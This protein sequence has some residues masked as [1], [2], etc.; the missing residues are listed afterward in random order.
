MAWGA[1]RSACRCARHVECSSVENAEHAICMFPISGRCRGS[2]PAK[3]QKRPVTG[4]AQQQ[5][6]RTRSLS[7]HTQHRRSYPLLDVLRSCARSAVRPCTRVGRG[8][9]YLLTNRSYLLTSHRPL[10][11]AAHLGQRR[12]L[13]DA[14][15]HHRSL[16]RPVPVSVLRTQLRYRIVALRIAH[17]YSPRIGYREYFYN[18]P[19]QTEATLPDHP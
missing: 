19:M 1:P 17:S 14:T 18:G 15:T 2:P 8:I 10:D 3:Q 12:F 5:R 11:L 6:R 4:N 9:T 13:H 16:Y 7:H